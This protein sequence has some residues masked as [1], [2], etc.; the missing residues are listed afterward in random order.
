MPTLDLR[1]FLEVLKKNGE[2]IAISDEVDLRYDIC[3]YL[4]QFDQIH[5]PALLFERIKG[6]SMKIAGNLV[7]TRKRLA[8]AFGLRSEEKLLETYRQRRAATI[9]PRRLK[10]GPVKEVVIRD[11]KKLDLE[12]LAIPTYHQ[13]DGG[14]YITCGILT[15]KDPATGLRSMGLH[16]LHVKGKRR[17][18]VHLTNPPISHFAAKAEE[19]GRPL[20]VA[21]SLG[22]HP[23]LLLA[24]IVSSAAEDKVAIAS[25]L[26]GSPL[27]LTKCETSD[28]DVP[29]HAEAVIEGRVLPNVR[30]LEG[31]F[32]ETSGYYFSDQSHVIEVTA[33]T[34]R[35]TAVLQA[36]HPTTQEVA[37]LGGP[38]GEAEMI[39]MLR[40]KGFDVRELTITV[41]S[42][43][44]HVVLS[45][46]KTHESEPRQLLHFLLAGV[47]FIKHAVVVDDDV[48]VH[49]ARDV[50]WAVATRFQGDED[51]V[52]IPGLRGRSIDPSKKEGLVT[53][54]VGLDATVPVA[55]KNRFKRIGVPAEVKDE[56]AKKLAAIMGSSAATAHAAMPGLQGGTK[57]KGSTPLKR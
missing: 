32:G 17:L 5:G 48:N 40:E 13:E 55:E 22:V 8:L 24:S 29:A 4:R 20:D 12:A 51:L 28:I 45:L 47:P 18:G 27:S 19:S 11:A 53:A 31:P 23:I 10:D 46:H 30:E 39:H 25:S 35:K 15:S 38:A 3:E 26:L 41:P 42:N 34:Y 57:D 56:V 33:I 49:D 9:K 16:R 36:L 54:K 1:N 43:R 52:I 21:I 7:G 37:L 14:P 44:T 50:E 2:L 6:Q